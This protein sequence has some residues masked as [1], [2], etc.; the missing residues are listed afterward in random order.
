MNCPKCGADYTELKTVKKVRDAINEQG[1][2]EIV[3]VAEHESWVHW[4]NGKYHCKKCG[5]VFSFK[6]GVMQ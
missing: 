1:R 6:E 3:F 4:E 2:R 5:H